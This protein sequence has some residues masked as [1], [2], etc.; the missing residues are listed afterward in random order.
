MGTRHVAPSSSSSSS[1]FFF[2][3]FFLLSFLSLTHSLFLSLPQSRPCSDRHP[4]TTVPRQALTKKVQMVMKP[5]DPV[6]WW[7]KRGGGSVL[8]LVR[9]A[10]AS[11]F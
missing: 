5:R 8:T 7:P 4:P 3:F 9:N 6:G 11:S 1:S 10:M 2:L